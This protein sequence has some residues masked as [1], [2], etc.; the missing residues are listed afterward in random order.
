M[1]MTLRNF[2]ISMLNHAHEHLGQFIAY[3]RMNSVVPPWSK[4]SEQK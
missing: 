4:S 3:A 2:M 1:E